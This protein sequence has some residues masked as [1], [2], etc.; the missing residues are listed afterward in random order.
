MDVLLLSRVQF[1]FT[2]AFHYIYPP[3]S[4]GLG[5]M[6]VIMEG[7]WLKTRNPLYHQM[8]RFW[9][10]IFALT[11]AIGVATDLISDGLVRHAYLGITGDDAFDQT[12]DAQVPRGALI[13]SFDEPSAL[14]SAGAQVGD[15]I[16]ALEGEP[17]SNMADLVALLRIRRA[18]ETVDV[19]VLRDGE[20]IDILVELAQR[21]ET[22]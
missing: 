20:Q 6:L 17:V 8:A 18:G 12:G 11:F 3:L 22:P 21:P 7:L 16:V 1:A 9:T 14:S 13:F 15:T 4:I 10:R 19:T 5:V 2:I